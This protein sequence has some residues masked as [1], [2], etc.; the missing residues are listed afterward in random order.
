MSKKHQSTVE[1]IT[2]A[3]QILELPESATIQQIRENFRR[4]V[5]KWHPDKSIE[6]EPICHEMT[7]KIILANQIIS[8]YCRQYKFS[9]SKEEI[10]KYISKK[11]WWYDKFGTDPIWSKSD[12]NKKK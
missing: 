10:K 11:E 5:S 8:D 7:E 12:L 6:K 2:W 1:K 3:R 4:L 9:F